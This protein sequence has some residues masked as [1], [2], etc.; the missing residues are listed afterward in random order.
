MPKIPDKVMESAVFLFPSADAARMSADTGGSGF[1]LVDR[2]EEGESHGYGFVYVVTNSHV[3][4]E[5]AC[6]VVRINTAAGGFDVIDLSSD[7]WIHHPAGDDVAVAPITLQD[8]WGAQPLEAGLLLTREY[9]DAGE[10]FG[11]GNEVFFIGRFV[12]RDGTVRNTPTA[13]FGNISMMP[14]EPIPHPTRGF[15]QDSFLVE[16]RSLSGYSGSPVFV[17]P[18]QFY[19][20]EG[21]SH[22]FYMQAGIRLLGVDWCHL[23][24]YQPVLESDKETPVSEKLYVR[25]NRG[26][27]GVVPAWKIR[28][29][30]DEEEL[31]EKRKAGERKQRGKG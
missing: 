29:L 8:A 7:A 20:P 18:A 14:N 3:I 10:F 26:I 28:E 9:A 24:R 5:G 23:P 16:A 17:D 25:E 30:L 1:L 19:K 21:Y 15:L 27:M 22:D 13:R 31:G 2:G 12:A 11:P 4:R 6:P